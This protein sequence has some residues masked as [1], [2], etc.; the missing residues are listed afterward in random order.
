MLGTADAL[1]SETT[2]N[3]RL[4]ACPSCNRHVR[5][6]ERACPCC[7]AALPESFAAAAYGAPAFDAGDAPLNSGATP[8]TDH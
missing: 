2:M 3:K 6:S 4:L 1:P 7:D 8:E 5:A